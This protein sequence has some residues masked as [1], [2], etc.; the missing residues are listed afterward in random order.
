MSFY[1][2]TE[3]NK[4][5]TTASG[6]WLYMYPDHVKTDKIAKADIDIELCKRTAVW[7]LGDK[8]GIGTSLRKTHSLPFLDFISKRHTDPIEAF[9]DY[10]EMLS[11]N[12]EKK[13]IP[14]NI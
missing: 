5:M 4:R 8:S 1:H 2:M 13:F 10:R 3:L 9:F 12:F 11:K 14:L 7:L 6:K